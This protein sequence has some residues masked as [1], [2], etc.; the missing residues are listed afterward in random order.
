MSVILK[1]VDTD[2]RGMKLGFFSAY[3]PFSTSDAMALR[4]FGASWQQK[5]CPCY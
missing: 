4:S 3:H 5:H 1:G 2:H